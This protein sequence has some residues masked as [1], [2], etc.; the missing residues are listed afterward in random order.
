[1][2]RGGAAI[3]R[4]S[5]FGVGGELEDR[6]GRSAWNDDIAVL[7]RGLQFL[8]VRSLAGRRERRQ[9][10]WREFQIEW[11]RYLLRDLLVRGLGILD[12]LIVLGDF[13]SRNGIERSGE[14]RRADIVVFEAV[15]V[16]ALQDDIESQSRDVLAGEWSAAVGAE[17]VQYGVIFEVVRVHLEGKLPER[18]RIVV[19]GSLRRIERLRRRERR[20]QQIFEQLERIVG[21]IA[22]EICV[23]LAERGRPVGDDLIDAEAELGVQKIE[24]EG[25]ASRDF[26]GVVVARIVVAGDEITAAAAQPIVGDREGVLEE[27]IAADLVG[28]QKFGGE[29]SRQ[30]FAFFA[31]VL[32]V[33][34]PADVL[35][36]HEDLGNFGQQQIPQEV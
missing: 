30:G 6:R 18:E 21:G 31:L 27:V 19:I 29:K 23:N 1:M 15:D 33:V 28:D 5:R 16:E 11:E 17:A 13:Q 35:G 14:R 22:G 8:L 2:R 32:A 20:V 12:A 9:A 34:V 24:K 4:S 7:D 3:R 10:G 26:V 25:R 36:R